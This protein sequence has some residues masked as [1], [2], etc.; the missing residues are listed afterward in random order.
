[1]RTFPKGDEALVHRR[2]GVLERRVDGHL[3]PDVRM[4]LERRAAHHQAA[5]VGRV[6]LAAQRLA[7]GAVIHDDTVARPGDEILQELRGKR[8]VLGKADVF[9]HR[10]ARDVEVAR[11]EPGNELLDATIARERSRELQQPEAPWPGE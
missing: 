6:A 2:A 11:A 7:A 4:D 1:M 5:D 3:P 10:D 9:V 8:R